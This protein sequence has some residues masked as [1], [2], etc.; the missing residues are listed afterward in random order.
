[1][2]TSNGVPSLMLEIGAANRSATYVSG[3]GSA[4]LCFFYTD[5]NE[6]I[7]AD[8]DLTSTTSLTLNGCRINDVAGN[9]ASLTLPT[10]R[11]TGFLGANADLVIIGSTPATLTLINAKPGVTEG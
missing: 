5:Q 3:S 1:M 9:N 8:L 6:D 4:T 2:T 10:Y 7:S 11:T